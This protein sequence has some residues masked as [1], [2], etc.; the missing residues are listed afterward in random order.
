MANTV[1][2]EKYPQAAKLDSLRTEAETAGQFYEWLMAK[3]EL[4]LVRYIDDE[5]DSE[6][7]PVPACL[8]G[9]ELVAEF[10]GID[11]QAYQLEKD[12]MLK[13]IQERHERTDA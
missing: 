11:Y 6:P 4:H 12:A 7:V 1:N 3:P 5:F 13:E 2:A 9:Q 10:L 8:S